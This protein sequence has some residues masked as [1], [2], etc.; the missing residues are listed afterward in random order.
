MVES[1]KT[2]VIGWPI[3]HSR[4]PL[5]HGYWLKTYN[6]P[7]SYE[8][9]ALAPEKAELFFKD[10]AKGDYIG[11]NITI[12][13]KVAVIPHLDVMEEAAKAIG[14]VNTIWVEDGKLHGTNTDWLGF[15]G[16]LDAGCAGW[17][18]TAKTALVLGAGGAARG[19]IYALIQ[20]GFQQIH[21][22]NRTIARAQEMQ[23][24]FG[25]AVL[26]HALEDADKLVGEC[27][28]IVNTTSLGM[29]KNPPLTLSLETIRPHCLVTDIVY[30]PLE[31][32]L[33]RRAKDKGVKT[34]D[35]L[36]MLL[37]QAA[38]G[39]ERWFGVYPTVD[40][41]LRQLILKDMG[42]AQ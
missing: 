41:E 5:I 9:I 23:T 22:A 42:Q 24:H 34:V 28:L 38:P 21:V 6:I 25:S 33:L 11:A 39:F 3:S 32:P 15:L 13:H 26:P 14:A 40:D 17:D 29:E 1:K 18:K 30:T 4:S 36:G 35:G 7:G 2:G 27:D 31:T 8:A 10:F 12:P 16:N 20:R 37:H 19:I